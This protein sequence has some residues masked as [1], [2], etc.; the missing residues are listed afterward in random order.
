MAQGPGITSDIH[1]DL[2]HLFRRESGKVVAALVRRFGV[3]HI[4]LA[5]DIVQD[6]LL[7]ALEQWPTR[8]MPEKP[9]AWLMTA[10]RN[11]VV[12][13]LRRST[14][15]MQHEAE[16]GEYFAGLGES[17]TLEDSRLIADDTLRMIFA[18]AHPALP[19]ESQIILVLRLMF[20]FKVSAIAEAFGIEEAAAAKRLVRAKQK[21]RELDLDFDAELEIDQRLAAVLNVL[22]LIFALGYNMPG[23]G[24]RLAADVCADALYLSR[25]LASHPQMCD[26]RISAVLALM[27]YQSARMTGDKHLLEEADERLLAAAKGDVISVYHIEAAIARELAQTPTN[28]QEVVELYEVLVLMTD[29]GSVRDAL[30]HARGMAQTR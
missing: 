30:A 25:E 1:R 2:D 26:P 8:G 29:S 23:S 13:H 3:E 27:L 4:D 12:D 24:S 19:R 17:I 22:Y 9:L 5:E 15:V 14:F 11:R 18:C 28:W 10:A 21:I 6:V 7:I 20:G 16:I